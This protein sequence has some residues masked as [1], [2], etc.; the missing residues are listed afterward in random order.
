MTRY[1]RKMPVIRLFVSYAHEDDYWMKTL[2]PLLSFSGVEAKP[3][4]DKEIRPGVRWDDAIKGELGKMHVFIPL[5]SVHFAVSNYIKNVECLIAKARMA[6]D[7]IE[8]IPVYLAH[9]GGNECDWLMELQRLPPGDKPWAEIFKEFQL[10]DLALAPI[11]DGIRQVVDR[12][13][14]RLRK[15]GP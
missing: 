6:K 11:R 1:P 2:M 4:S 15:A 8:V 9:T 3:W 5:V 7:E 14:E 12:A 13:R 10:H